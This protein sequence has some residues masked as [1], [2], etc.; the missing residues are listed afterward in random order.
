M[1]LTPGVVAGRVGF[2]RVVS[3]SGEVSVSRG[4]VLAS[5]EVTVSWWVADPTA[6]VRSIRSVALAVASTAAVVAGI[7]VLLSSC[8]INHQIL[9]VSRISYR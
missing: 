8:H 4:A 7:R 9:S 5:G 1:A 3:G 2:R 6:T